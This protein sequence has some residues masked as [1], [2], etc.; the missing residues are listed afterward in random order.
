MVWTFSFALVHYMDAAGLLYVY[1]F[2]GCTVVHLWGLLE[3]KLPINNISQLT[4]ITKQLLWACLLQRP[5]DI[6]MRLQ[7]VGVQA[8]CGTDLWQG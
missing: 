5:G 2:S 8:R 4:D 7:R 6:Q 3:K 1:H